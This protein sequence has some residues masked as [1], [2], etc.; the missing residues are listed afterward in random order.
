MGVVG[1]ALTTMAVQEALTHGAL[2]D[3]RQGAFVTVTRDERAF[4][5]WSLEFPDA[6]A[7]GGFDVILGNPPF[8]GGIAHQRRRGRSVPALAGSGVCAVRR[9]PPTSARRSSG[10]R[11]RCCAPAGAWG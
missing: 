10:G 9:Q 4:F 1:V 11:L 3:P 5:H 2:S 6:A 8:I 7:A